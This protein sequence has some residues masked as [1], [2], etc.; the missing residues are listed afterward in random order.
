LRRH[1][2]QK[3]QA[4]CLRCQ[5]RPCRPPREAVLRGEAHGRRHLRHR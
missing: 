3:K 5:Q 2:Q 4:V 1:T